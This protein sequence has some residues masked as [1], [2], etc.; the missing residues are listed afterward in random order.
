[1]EDKVAPELNNFL[2]EI[3][4]L[5]AEDLVLEANRKYIEYITAL[6]RHSRNNGN[7]KLKADSYAEYAFFLFSHHN[8][9]S[10]FEMLRR[11]QENGYSSDT[12]QKIVNEAFIEP[13][14]D[15]FKSIYNK[16]IEYLLSNEYIEVKSILTFEDLPYWLMPIETENEYYLFDKKNGLL[17]E[18]I[19]LNRNSELE[20]LPTGDVFSDYLLMEN[21]SWENTLAYTTKIRNNNKK[22]YIVIEN[23]G[24][25][26]S[27]LQGE[28]LNEEIISN[29]MI[30]E[31][32]YNME[33]HFVN[34][35][36]YL[37]RNIINLVDNTNHIQNY[38][39][40]IHNYRINKKERARNNILLSI[41]IPSFNRGN[42]AY[43]NIIH[44]LQSKY[45][46]E[47][48]FIVSNNGTQNDTQKYYEKIKD[49]EDTRVKY[50]SFE[51]N[52]GFA[53]NCSKAC[54]LAEG[55]YILLLS[56]EDLVDFNVLDK[57]MDE[58]MRSKETLAI[59]R[60][61]TIRQSKPAVKNAVQGKDALLT[62][63]LT[64]N[65]M[66]G[67]I[68]NNNLLKKH[69]GIEYVKEN[70]DNKVCYNYPHMFWELLL[71]QYGNVL[72]TDLVLVHEGKAEKTE[73]ELIKLSGNKT[74]IYSYA[75]F[76]GRLEQHKGF[77]TIFKHLDI[78]KEDPNLF[79]EMY[80]R[81]CAKTLF[82]VS[83][84]LSA[85][86]KNTDINTS[87]M[88]DEAYAFCIRGEFLDEKSKFFKEDVRIIKGC[89]DQ[90]QRR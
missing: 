90:Y 40:V 13:N 3:D 73:V 6:E 34:S 21:G 54:E 63:M 39:N 25:F 47:I 8:Y 19:T 9:E 71:G 55:E 81:L 4:K 64:S 58:L 26:F 46:E 11:A 44:L 85:F 30:F 12:I 15:E 28:L 76:E 65:Y 52:K 38:I 72:G 86:Y 60:T 82:L 49:I 37:P 16:N 70:L 24:K 74:E 50:F 61:S 78:C 14:L 87:T 66:S 27:C 69:K 29:V 79:R 20:I 83:H 5:I 51:E 1:M 53:L 22:A 32:L 77:F 23:I 88:L 62:F 36:D 48:E 17:L 67:I 2:H 41:C 57:I 75:T 56:D 59:V 84:S 35:N 10:F 18:K 7:K 33:N 68:L 31:D 80:I 42:R 45:D 89:Y 43:E